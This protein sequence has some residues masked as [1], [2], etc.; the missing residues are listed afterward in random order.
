[1]LLSKSYTYYT[2]VEYIYAKVC[3]L[4]YICCPNNVYPSISVPLEKVS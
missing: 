2:Y 1:M 3:M 4:I